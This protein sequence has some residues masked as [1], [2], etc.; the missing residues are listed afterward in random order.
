MKK[1]ISLSDLILSSNSSKITFEVKKDLKNLRI[2]ECSK[3][4]KSAFKNFDKVKNQPVKLN[5]TKLCRR[6][7]KGQ[8]YCSLVQ[9][10]NIANQ[11]QKIK[12]LKKLSFLTNIPERSLYYYKAQ[13][14]KIPLDRYN[15]IIISLKV[16]E[17]IY[18]NSLK[19]N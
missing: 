16:L 2:Y 17:E 15:R 12:G 18:S 6:T 5:L 7:E 19:F 11:L 13:K 3:T 8:T 9:E 14:V 10:E 1:S 4:S